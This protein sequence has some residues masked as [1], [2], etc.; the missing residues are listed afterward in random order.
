MICPDAKSTSADVSEPASACPSPAN[1]RNSKK[2]ALSCASAL[3]IWERTSAIIAVNCSNV[4]VSRIGLS[5]FTER[6]CAVGETVKIRSRKAE[7]NTSLT[8]EIW[9]LRDAEPKR[10]RDSHRSTSLGLILQT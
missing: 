9:R 1:P 10:Y 5:R 4:G 2:S 6:R 8:H 7:L 3:T